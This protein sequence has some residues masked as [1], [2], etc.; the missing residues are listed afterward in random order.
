MKIKLLIAFLAL[1]CF[2]ATVSAQDT[3]ALDSVIVT[4]T[5][6]PDVAAGDSSVVIEVYF[7]T[8]QT[9]SSAGYGMSWDFDGFEMDTV[10]FTPAF[11]TAF[12]VTLAWA[13]SDI[14]STNFK[15]LFQCTGLSFDVNYWTAP[16]LAATFTGHVT[17]WTDGDV[18]TIVPHSF[19][20]TGFAPPFPDEEYTPVWGGDAVLADVQVLD[21]GN[22]P[23]KFNL[24]Q[25]YPNPFNPETIIEFD[26][27]QRTEVKLT[28]FNVLGQQ[29]VT[30]INKDM[31]PG[32]Y[33]ETWDGT[34]DSGNKVASGIYFYRL[35]AGEVVKTKKMMLLK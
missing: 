26:L 24:G 35:I 4:F 23:T 6:M 22:L 16:G 7:A 13:Q 1:C 34:S 17:R 29:V 32:Y 20:P 28:I 3:G 14:D 33:R 10:V 11:L 19:V 12:N 9:I 18:I 31:Q 21:L 15:R 2:G 5:H 27:P 25:N 8:D 30:L